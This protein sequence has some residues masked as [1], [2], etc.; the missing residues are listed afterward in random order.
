M[1][2]DSE[3]RRPIRRLMRRLIRAP[4]MLS[5]VWPLMLIIGAYVAWDRWGA[6]YIHGQFDGVEPSQIRITEPPEYVYSDIVQTVYDDTAMQGLSLLD[7]QATAKIASAFSTNPWIKHVNSVR[8]L[9]GG[10]ID[11]RVDYRKPVAMVYVPQHREI[12]RD[13][14]YAVDSEGVL[15]PTMDFVR[16]GVDL[17]SYIHIVV[18]EMKASG[19]FGTKIGD[20]RAESAAL[21][22]GVLEPFRDQ[23]R[24]VTIGIYGDQRQTT[25]PQLELETTS[26]LTDQDGAPILRKKF[27]GSPPGMELPNERPAQLKLKALFS[28]GD[29]SVDLRYLPLPAAAP[30]Q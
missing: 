17:N 11:V 5:F 20:M 12:V 28:S 4:A 21:L 6:D 26:D 24:V 29:E 10:V 27:W 14:F 19:G 1:R 13:G 8:K 25:V 3:D 23:T 2:A 18:P 9:P 30:I 22:A 16:R 15:L 7:T